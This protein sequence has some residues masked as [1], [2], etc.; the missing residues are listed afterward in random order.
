MHGDLNF[1]H[2]YN[3]D[4]GCTIGYELFAKRKDHVELCAKTALDLLCNLQDLDACILEEDTNAMTHKIRG[5]IFHR[6]NYCELF[7]GASQ[8]VAGKNAMQESEV[9]LGIAIYF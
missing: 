2:P 6:W 5:E 1:F 9:H 7:A 3:Q 4:L 8:I